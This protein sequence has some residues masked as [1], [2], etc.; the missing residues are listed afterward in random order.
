[1]TLVLLLLVYCKSSQCSLYDSQER[2]FPK[3]SAKLHP[4]FFPTKFFA[5]KI[6]PPKPT[7]STN[8]C[9]SAPYH[10][11]KISKKTP[12]ALSIRFCPPDTDISPQNS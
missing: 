8:H 1:M 12:Q 7:F 4:K 6:T 11:K 10:I 2:C 3:A 5:K 9:N